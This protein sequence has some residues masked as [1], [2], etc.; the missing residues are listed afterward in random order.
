MKIRI[1]ALLAL[2]LVLCS[3]SV[4]DAVTAPVG[5]AQIGTT[6]EQQ[7]TTQ[8][9]A[10]AL[11][12][13]AARASIGSTATV[14]GP[15]VSTFTATKSEG[16]PTFLNLGVDHPDPAG[17]TVVIFG[18]HRSAFPFDP[19]LEY[20]AAEICVTGEIRPHEQFVQIEARTPEQITVIG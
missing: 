15:V 5:P 14:C 2:P 8:R 1:A 20:D 16:Q 6:I 3:C 10:G 12:W 19:A 11:D 9:P 13:S 7:E 18:D 17:L 4:V